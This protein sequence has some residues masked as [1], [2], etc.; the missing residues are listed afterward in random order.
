MSFRFRRPLGQRPRECQRISLVFLLCSDDE[1]QIL[2][3]LLSQVRNRLILFV[4][5]R[6]APTSN[7]KRKAVDSPIALRKILPPEIRSETSPA[8]RFFGSIMV[9]INCTKTGVTNG[10]K[11]CRIIKMTVDGASP[12]CSYQV[13]RR[14]WWRKTG[15]RFAHGRCRSIPSP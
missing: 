15:R 2:G 4:I 3:D 14:Q 1:V 11:L 10:L 9:P 6:G 13:R 7:S 12:E 8:S 5:L